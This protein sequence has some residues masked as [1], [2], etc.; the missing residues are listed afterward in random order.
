MENEKENKHPKEFTII[1][2][3]REKKVEKEL[4]SFNEIAALAFENPPTGP[5]VVFTITWRH[6]HDNGTVVEGG[7]VEIKNG[8]IFNVTATDKS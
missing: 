5:N 3:G 4:L 8:M 6:G 7:S 2:N 1:V